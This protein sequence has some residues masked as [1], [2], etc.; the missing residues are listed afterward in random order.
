VVAGFR[1]DKVVHLAA[2]AGVRP[3]IERPQVYQEVNVGGTLNLLDAMVGAGC[4]RLVF[5]STSS[6][7]GAASR[8][9]F[10]E[11]DVA[12]R[13]VSPYAATKRAA[14][15][16]VYTYHHLHGLRATCLR[17]FTVFGPR[18]RPEMAIHRFA[19]LILSGEPV[20]MF[21]DGSSVRDYTYVD[22]VMDG[23]KKALDFDEGYGIY[24]I[25]E[26][27]MTRLR[28]LVDMIAEALGKTAR[29]QQLGD[30]PGDVPAT[31]ADIAKAR[32][33][34]GYDPKVPIEEGIRRFAAWLRENRG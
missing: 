29:I 25:G 15:L 6:V 20:P 9:P 18:Q 21:G 19:R 8:P 12:D 3:S 23:I 14:E 5:G 24:N 32:R 13:P 33:V 27:R 22:D 10:K 28:D 26:C 1:P 30:Q 2:M 4:T 7:Y 34:L 31:G 11:T 17:F 16:M